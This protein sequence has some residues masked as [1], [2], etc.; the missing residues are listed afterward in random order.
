MAEEFLRT[1]EV[2]AHGELISPEVR[3]AGPQRFGVAC[4]W[5]LL[6]PISPAALPEP[7][8]SVPTRPATPTPVRCSPST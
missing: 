2:L 7:L 4:G 6:Y 1:D 3:G 8:R 5:P